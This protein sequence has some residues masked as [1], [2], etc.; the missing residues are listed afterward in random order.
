MRF[1]CCRRG[2]DFV[3]STLQGRVV[4]QSEHPLRDRATLESDLSTVAGGVC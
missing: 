1:L 4:L 2:S 3:I